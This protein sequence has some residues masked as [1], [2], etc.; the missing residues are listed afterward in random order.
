MAKVHTESEE[1]SVEKLSAFLQNNKKLLL[2]MAAA[3]VAVVGAIGIII[4]VSQSSFTNRLEEV[5][6]LQEE[7]TALANTTEELEE[8][9]LN[10]R[11]DALSDDLD[12][13]IKKARTGYPELRALYLKASILY[14]QEQYAEA[15]ESFLAAAEAYPE[16]HLA[17]S[18]YMNS[19]A[20]YEQSGD[21]N[22]AVDAYRMVVS[23][24][25]SSA[26]ATPHAMFSIARVLE[27]SE[28]SAEAVT[29]YRELADRYPSSEWGKLALSR[30]LALE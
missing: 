11:F 8:T 6:L 1:T 9:E 16:S 21:R 22:A 13:F 5:E 2:I 4:A 27:A 19:G 17:P 29:Q 20:S 18:A 30:L 7:F 15:A 25:G 26:S 24:F 14:S 23:E 12:A 28:N 10:S 3:V